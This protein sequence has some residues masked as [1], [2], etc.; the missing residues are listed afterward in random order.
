VHAV[1]DRA[2]G[3]LT[4]VEARPQAREHLPAD[5][6]VQQRD[7]VD[8]LGQPHAHDGHVEHL[9]VAARVGLRAQR[10]HP[11][12]GQQRVVVKVL[13]DQLATEPVDA[14][15]DRRVGGEHRAGPAHLDG[16]LEAQP[17][18]GVLADPLQAE[19]PGVP[20]VGVEH[21]G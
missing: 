5:L 3:H 13:P 21:L 6:A 14:R 8:P 12:D 10:E 20:L 17:A 4:G 11:V 1:G 18:L 16:L 19:E 2:D 9:G 15:R 7:P